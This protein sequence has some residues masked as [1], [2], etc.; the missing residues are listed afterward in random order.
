MKLGTLNASVATSDIQRADR[1]LSSASSAHV[2]WKT[3]WSLMKRKTLA[4]SYHDNESAT[5]AMIGACAFIKVF[6]YLEVRPVEEKVEIGLH[7]DYLLH[8]QHLGPYYTTYVVWAITPHSPDGP[9]NLG[10]VQMLADHSARMRAT[11]PAR[12]FGL[13]VT[14]EPHPLVAHPSPVIVAENLDGTGKN[15][16]LTQFLVEYEGDPG[17]FYTPSFRSG[18]LAQPDFKTPLCVIGARRAVDIACRVGAGECVKTILGQAAARFRQLDRIWQNSLNEGKFQEVQNLSLETVRLAE[19]ARTMAIAHATV[20]DRANF[21]PDRFATEIDPVR[22]GIR[23]QPHDDAIG[24]YQASVLRRMPA[25]IPELL[26]VRREERGMVLRFSDLLFHR[27]HRF[28]DENAKN[29]LNRLT[30]MLLTALKNYCIAIEGHLD[31]T[32]PDCES[33]QI[34][35]DRAIAVRRQLLQAGL[36]ADRMVSTIGLGKQHPLAG[37]E[38]PVG[39]YLNRR[40]EII[41]ATNRGNS[42][43]RNADER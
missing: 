4:L 33:E 43:R 31:A 39:R 16:R 17:T 29:S 34:S 9:V 2:G 42:I 38:T 19:S 27:D 23:L 20:S 35:Q 8:P 28:L 5:I 30:G 10:Q 40:I 41:L 1:W 21:D 25:Q 14:A 11:I 18:T 26:E 12:A 7:L 3:P 15:G 13:I 6:G 22:K 32:R 24:R 36:P 37:N